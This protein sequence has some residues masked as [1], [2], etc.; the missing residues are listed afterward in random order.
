MLG[1]FS[2]AEELRR[3]K[4]PRPSKTLF[5][6]YFRI[7]FTRAT[8]ICLLWGATSDASPQQQHRVTTGGVAT[9]EADQQR[10]VGKVFF[11]DGN[12]DIVFQ[13]KRLRG[14]HAEY[15]D[16]T[17]TAFI[18]GHVQFDYQTEHL[19]ATDGSY[20]LETG[21]G[22]FHN[23][24][25][26]ITIQRRPNPSLLIS[27][28]PFSFTAREV[29]RLGDETYVLMDA[30]ITVCDPQRPKWT[31]HARRATLHVEKT[32]QMEGAT[33]RLVS[34]P[35]IYL[36]YASAPAGRK[37]RQS[38]FLIPDISESSVKGLVV[39][40]SY[41]WAPTEWMDATVGGA[42]LSK[43]GFS[44]NDAIR[45]RPSDNSHFD[46][47][48]YGV[49]D[50]GIDGNAPQGGHKFHIGGDTLLPHGWRAVADLNDLSSLTFQL[51]FSET[52]TQAV[53]SEVHNTAFLTNNFRGFSVNF[54]ALG[55][56]NFFSASP[57]TQITLRAAPEARVGSVDQSPW[58]H[59]PVYFGFDA[60]ADAVHRDDN[61]APS[62]N[63]PNFVQRYEFAPRVTIPLHWG[64]WLG[65]TPSFTLRTTYYGGQLFNNTFSNSAFTR[66]TEEF[67]LDLRPAAIERIWSSGDEKWKHTVEPELTYN[68]VNGVTDFAHFI[69]YDEDETLTDTNEVEY[70]ITQRLFMKEG[71]EGA[72]EVASLR[73]T[74][75]YFF[76]PTF[77]GALAPGQRNVFQTLDA[78]TPFA[79]ANVA[80]RFS[81]IISDLR[82]D[83]G[84]IYDAQVRADYDPVRGKF[85]GI[86]TLLK[87]KPYHDSFITLGN[88]S[89]INIPSSSTLLPPPNPSHSP[90]LLPPRSNQIRA[91]V[92]Y[93]D[94]NRP[95]WNADV[96]V[97][98]DVTENIFQNQVAQLSYNGSC[99][100]IGLEYRR[101]ELGNVR[102]EN[103][104]RIVFLIANIG[105][106]G[107]L[108]RQEKIF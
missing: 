6:L 17:R 10:Q 7:L 90:P 23:V 96:G 52:F 34:I 76:D 26:T 83:P 105:S 25:G 88:F 5:P 41:Y 54:A 32:L 107:N 104:F 24:T 42:W 92:G 49:D 108:R 74:Q 20:N 102:V 2:H 47:S 15:H 21:K 37:V 70:G 86:G 106:A 66:T 81:P 77:G 51:V 91:L 75:K 35:V 101:F 99:C 4:P 33:F 55:Y 30:R 71:D 103:Q 11:A 97:S 94:L 89:T 3:M 93:G 50:R 53:N 31:F 62:F 82:L 46:F 28:N 61:S 43:R 9:L 39:G 48:F 56:Q 79:F 8:I 73:L 29:R 65:A 95:G 68:L 40:D 16:D 14:D 13:D 85:T 36:P 69:R 44:Q 18:R 12:V 27:D 87:L 80:R 58:A 57:Q 100:G 45:M 19:E 63:T 60:F 59:I 1:S 72:Q 78:L 22:I 38:G 64:S 67:S 84:G 98:Y